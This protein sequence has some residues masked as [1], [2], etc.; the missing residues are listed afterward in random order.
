MFSAESEENRDLN[1]GV[2]VGGI[3]TIDL[4]KYGSSIAMELS[5]CWIYWRRKYQDSGDQEL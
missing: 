5:V 2:R 4:I 1:G 3:H